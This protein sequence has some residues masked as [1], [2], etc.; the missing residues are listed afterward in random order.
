MPGSW[1]RSKRFRV[2]GAPSSLFA[3]LSPVKRVGEGLALGR[4][5]EEEPPTRGTA[6]EQRPPS[7]T[8]E[9][10]REK[11]WERRQKSE[12]RPTERHRGDLHVERHRGNLQLHVER[13]R[14][15]L[16]VERHEDMEQERKPYSFPASSSHNSAVNRQ[17][18]CFLKKCVRT[19][20]RSIELLRWSIKAF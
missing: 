18:F 17:G 19:W 15:D 13:H 1:F 14:G 20:V 16:H 3:V 6:E 10:R 7:S 12:E 8:G 5:V 11:V 9:E 4:R 2:E